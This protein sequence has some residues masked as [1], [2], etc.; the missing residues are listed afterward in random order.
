VRYVIFS[1]YVPFYQINTLF[2][3]ILFFHYCG[4]M[5]FARPGDMVSQIG[6]GPRA[7]V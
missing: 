3:N 6:F 2:V 7:V 4:K 5:Y 1:G